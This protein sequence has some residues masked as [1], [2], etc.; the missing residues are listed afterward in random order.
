MTTEDLNDNAVIFSLMSFGRDDPWRH[1]SC[2]GG[3]H[4]VMSLSC[5][6]SRVCGLI[7]LVVSWCGWC[8]SLPTKLNF[9]TKMSEKHKST[10]PSAI[11]VKNW[12]ETI[13]TEEKL[14]VISWLEKGE[15][16]VDI[17]HNVK[18]THSSVHTICDNAGRITESAKSRN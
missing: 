10:S 8:T 4:T 16:I 18:L 9:V 15:Q 5:H 13:S 11:Q 2:V 14:D 6:Q 17:C 1:F 12:W 7:T 3:W